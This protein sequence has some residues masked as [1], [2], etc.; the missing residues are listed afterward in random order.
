MYNGLIFS[1]SPPSSVTGYGWVKIL[2]DG[3]HE[4]YHLD[5][6][7]NTWVLDFTIPAPALAE[8]T[9]EGLD[10]LLDIITLLSSGITGSREFGG[11]K[12]TFNHGV[13]VG[14]EQV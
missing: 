12:F 7:S 2:E 6:I 4:Y 13:L 5:N 1:S 3:S 14:F 9:H 10:Q 8:H 11:Y